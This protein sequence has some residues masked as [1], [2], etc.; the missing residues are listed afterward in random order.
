MAHTSGLSREWNSTR[1][2][3]PTRSSLSGRAGRRDGSL[4]AIGAG[5]GEYRP[6]SPLDRRRLPCGHGKAGRQLR[7]SRRRAR[8]DGRGGSPDARRPR[9][10][11]PG[12]RD[13]RRRPRPRVRARW[14]ADRA[15]GLLRGLGVRALAPPG[16]RGLARARAGVGPGPA[17]VVRWDLHRRPREP[18]LH[19]QPRLRARA[20]PR[21]RGARR[22]RDRCALPDD[23]AA[24]ARAG[25]V[26]GE[27]RLRPSGGDGAGQRRPGPSG[28]SR[29]AL[30]RAGHPLG[31]DPWRGRGSRHLTRALRRGPARTDP[32]RVGVDSAAA[33]GSDRGGATNLLLARAGLH[34]RGPLRGLRRGPPP[35]TWRRPT[36]TGSCT[37]SRWST[38][39]PAGSSSPSTGRTTG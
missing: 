30:L 7:R 29:P 33:T 34:C 12:A 6:T 37:A 39:P 38:G 13:L 2:V 26:R 11:G 9:P 35:S 24:G 4:P 17:A 36:A 23:A 5:R 3:E 25:D 19:R 27:R 16:I 8:V 20:R 15:S 32:R 22:R 28:R 1:K 21:A 31:A 10:A 18:R 14:H